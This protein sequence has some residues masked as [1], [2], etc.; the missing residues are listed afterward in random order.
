MIITYSSRFLAGFGAN[1]SNIKLNANLWRNLCN[2]GI[3]K[4]KPTRRG[5]RAGKCKQQLLQ[6]SHQA[7]VPS[8]NVL[9]SSNGISTSSLASNW[10]E[11]LLSSSLN[12]QHLPS[13]S[14]NIQD[15]TFGNNNIPVLITFSDYQNTQSGQARNLRNLIAI[16]C[17]QNTS[18]SKLDL[19]KFCLA[20]CRSVRNKTA[21]IVDYIT[22]DCK[23]DI[24]AITETWLEHRDDAVRVELCPDGYKLYDHPREHR[25]GGGTALLCKEYLCVNKVDAGSKTSYEFSEFVINSS[26]A[27]NLRLVIIYRPPYSS[28]YKVSTSV[29]FTEFFNYLESLLLCK[30]PLVICG[31]FNIHV[32]DNDDGDSVIFCD[33]LESVGLRQHVDQA[34]HVNGHILDLVITRLSDS[35]ILNKPNID[36]YISDHACVT[37]DFQT[38]KP[39]VQTRKVAYR[40]LKSVDS[41]ALRSDLAATDLCTSNQD[42]C[43]YLPPKELDLCVKAYD[44]TLTDLINLHAPLKTKTLKTRPSMPWYNSEIDAAKRLR[45]KLE[46]VWLKSKSLEDFQRFKT[47]RNHVTYIINMAKKAY[48]T[49]FIAKNSDNQAK[50]FKSAKILLTAKDDI[51]FPNHPDKDVLCD[52]IGEF[53]V[54]KIAKIREE[55]DA[56]DLSTELCD[57]VPH[58]QSLP[59]GCTKLEYFKPLSEEE[60]R[61]LISS[62]S[63]KHCALDPM[64]SSLIVDC[65]DELLPVITKIVNSSL[66][67]GHFP[68]DW[69]EALVKPLKKKSGLGATF[70][71]LRPISNLKFISKLTERAAYNQICN[72]LME[73]DLLPELQSAYRQRYSTETALLKVQN[74][75]FLSMNRQHVT[76]LVLLDLSAAFDTV[77]HSVLL[78]RMETTFGISGKALEWF[79]SYLSGR[80][81]R[82][83]LEGGTSKQF[84]LLCGLPQGSCLGPLLF[85]LYS[86]KLFNIIEQ[87]LPSA[88][89]YADDTQ[90]YL[91]FKPGCILSEQESIAAMESCINAIRAWMV[92]DKLKINDMKTEFLI[93]GTKQQLK[94]LNTDKLLVGDSI[95]RPTS[96]ARN[97]GVIF[98]ENMSL[99]HHINNTCKLAFYSIH[100]IRSI[101]KYLSVEASRTLVHSVVMGRLDY[102][103][104]LLYGLPAKSLSKLQRVQNAA[105]R[106]ITNTPKYNHVTPVLRTLHWLPIKQRVI[107][108]IVIMSFKAIY[109]LAPDYISNLVSIQQPSRYFLRRNSELLIK[110]H[111]IKSLKTLGDRAF[112]VASPT[113]FNQLPHYV[114]EETNFNTFKTLVKT[115]LFKIAYEQ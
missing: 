100:N 43:D 40:K 72:H 73:N 68:Q 7:E 114:R 15:S 111:N 113:V 91:S 53:F 49:D 98:D 38:P 26:S 6:T 20:N 5:C 86:S 50:L 87:Y 27:Y 33:L 79:S 35:I 45:R 61:S 88:H 25:R 92:T 55:I 84:K 78:E 42:A 94:K 11:H 2:L 22:K 3:S 23:P 29:F 44:T 30:E 104:S 89:A 65:L 77:D 96:T 51:C 28:E 101:R 108:K 103:N 4:V 24:F 46:K 82:V 1:L 21:N 69:K 106:L 85:T 34:T 18:N 99:S 19:L 62:S 10:A 14:L 48:Y 76:L 60:I 52:E 109:G 102:C 64:P 17:K 12:I 75:I 41:D 57:L 97:L 74:D 93:I 37:C 70:N 56:T 59:A 9:T 83:T 110:P 112:S 16:T 8:L 67:Q 90:L 105:A 54:H 58:D 80:L 47:Q 115:H 71:N 39:M 81:Q 95:I 36:H 31:D 107:Y 13:L 66:V 32:D 63:K